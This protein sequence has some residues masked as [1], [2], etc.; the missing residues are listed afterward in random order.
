MTPDE[1]DKQIRNISS[2]YNSLEGE[3]IKIIARRLNRG[4]RDITYW[5]AQKLQELRLFNSEVVEQLSK[6][7]KVSSPQIKQIFEDVG[8][9]SVKDIDKAMPY[10]TKPLPTQLDTVLKGYLEQARSGV[11]NYVNQS[12]ITTTYGI[13]TAQMAYTEVLNKT[14]SWFN[15][16]LYNFKDALE[17][18]IIE[19]AQKGIGS[20]LIDK[21]GR[22]WN[23]EGYVRSVLK[24][25][26]GRT[27]N[28]VRKERMAEY[29]VYTVL[30]S[31]HAGARP[32]C[33]IIQGNVVDLRPMEEI[34]EDSPYKS[35]YDPYWQAEY[36]TP[37]GHRGVNCKHLH[38]PFI[39]GVNV[40]NQP[41]FD[42]ELNER[43]RV[44]RDTQRRIEREIV[45]YKKNL[46][47]AEE[48]GSDKVG[49][50]QGMVRKRQA[51]MREHLKNNGE[52]LG[53]DYTRE[54]VYTPLDTLLKDF[55]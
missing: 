7:T 20:G 21:G 28:T 16:G 3:I 4:N 29:G 12:L 27:Y 34:P 2:M 48:L 13:G 19:L 46:I 33:S 40:N 10:P 22:R 9:G 25:T 30:V 42:E 54:K 15:A 5:Q 50:W 1:L 8:V 43:V 53:R 11:D 31:S 51:A 52:Y 18:S 37:G 36:E 14:A 45:K 47:V 6:V 35:V 41:V 39:P 44:H 38:F 17:K 24:S 23:L 49:Y 32:A 26:L 55:E